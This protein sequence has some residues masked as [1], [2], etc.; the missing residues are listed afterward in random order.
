MGHHAG[1]A[2]GGGG[3]GAPGRA[4]AWREPAPAAWRESPNFYLNSSSFCTLTSCWCQDIR[5]H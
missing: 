3:R 5:G 4:V 1:P 2:L